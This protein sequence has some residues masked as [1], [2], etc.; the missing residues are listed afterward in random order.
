MPITFDVTDRPAPTIGTM[1]QGQWKLQAGSP[2][3]A[4]VRPM[5][6]PAPTVLANHDSAGWQFTNG[7]QAVRLS[8]PELATLQG[9]PPD[10]KWTGT[11]TQQARMV[12]NAVPPALAA[13]VASVNRP[14]TL[15]RAA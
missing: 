12:G 9:F 7:D 11:K 5:D 10:W 4:T 13:A 14:I 1:V 2:S 15:E 8:I 3:N 6:E